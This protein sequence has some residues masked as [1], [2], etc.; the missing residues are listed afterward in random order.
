MPVVAISLTVLKGRRKTAGYLGRRV[1]DLL[2]LMSNER[3]RK[4]PQR[5]AA[6]GHSN[7]LL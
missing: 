1:G 4:S 6:T 7:P 3:K 2:D 5:M